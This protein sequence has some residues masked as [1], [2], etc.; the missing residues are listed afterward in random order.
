MLTQSTHANRDERD[1][2]ACKQH[3][4]FT[5]TE[6]FGSSDSCINNSKHSKRVKTSKE[7]KLHKF[8]R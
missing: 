3:S 8:G 4:K 6:W 7:N 2:A 1:A 5:S